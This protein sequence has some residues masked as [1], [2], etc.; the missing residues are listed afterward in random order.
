MTLDEIGDPTVV[1]CGTNPRN[2][3]GV[4]VMIGITTTAIAEATGRDRA[5]VV[6]TEIDQDLQ[7]EEIRTEMEIGTDLGIEAHDITMTGTEGTDEKMIQ[8]M[9][10]LDP[11]GMSVVMILRTDEVCAS[12]QLIAL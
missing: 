10:R 2:A 4:E 1:K 7:I 5:N 8:R 3:I 11:D 6:D 12:T 9:R